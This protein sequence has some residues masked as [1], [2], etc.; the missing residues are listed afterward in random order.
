MNPETNASPSNLPPRKEADSGA[1]DSAV[2]PE[3]ALEALRMEGVLP[4]PSHSVGTSMKEAAPLLGR[5]WGQYRIEEKIGQGGMGTVFKS[6]D[7]KLN[8]TVA[9]KVL[10]CGPLDDPRTAERFQREA[11]CLARLSHPNLLHVYN[12]GYEGEWHYF[13]ME[14]LEGSTLAQFLRLQKRMETAEL[15]ALAGPL[16]GA[17]HYIHAQGITHRDI[18]CGNIMVCGDRAVLMDFGLAKDELQTGLTSMGSVLGTPEYMA[19]ELAEG[20]SAGPPTDLY[21]L[22]V[23]FFEA[24]AGRVPFQ[25]RS[26]MAIIRQHLDVAPPD[27]AELVPG[28]DPRWSAVVR[29]CLAKHPAERFADC[30]ALAAALL[31]IYPSSEL[32]KLAAADRGAETVFHPNIKVG[33]F[34][35]GKVGRG[36]GVDQAEPE[37]F[38]PARGGSVSTIATRCALP[39]K[40]LSEPRPAWVYVVFGFLGVSVLWFVGA[41]IWSAPAHPKRTQ[42]QPVRVK[43]GDGNTSDTEFRLVRFTPRKKGD[44]ASWEY[45]IELRGPDGQW[46]KETINGVEF[47]KR[48]GLDHPEA[49]LE[50][51][52]GAGPE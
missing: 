34:T 8:R 11:M 38:T 33:D 28:V 24:L 9:L 32:R 50:F 23:V 7:T 17:L 36:T 5:L 14:L 29:R 27:L 41:W 48:F 49:V 42:G 2:S 10:R 26:A 46:K 21:S 40:P 47:R 31:E 43:G 6:H 39:E 12:V 30:P 44:P 45:V 19:P 22:G 52:S 4:G 37:A 18:K 3:E 25:G 13:A 1:E 20:R 51:D 16:L 35:T 15:G